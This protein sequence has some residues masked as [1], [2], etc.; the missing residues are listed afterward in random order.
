MVRK[1]QFTPEIARAALARRNE[2]RDKGLITIGR[3]KGSFGPKKQ[4]KINSR[5]SFIAA[6]QS[7]AGKL[8]NDLDRNSSAGD[9]KAALG[10]LDRVG[11]TPVQKIEVEHKFSLI[12]LDGQRK[13]LTASPEMIDATKDMRIIETPLEVSDDE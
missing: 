1:G 13:A 8:L 5:E 3:P 12:G 4:A 7:I 2:M 10:I 11:I 9:S 6:G